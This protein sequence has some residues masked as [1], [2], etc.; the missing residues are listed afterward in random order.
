VV[1]LVQLSH[2]KN[3]T[4][5]KSLEDEFPVNTTEPAD[6]IKC[7]HNLAIANYEGGLLKRFEDKLHPCLLELE[8]ASLS[9]DNLASLFVSY[10]PTA[11]TFSV[12]LLQALETRVNESSV[13]AAC[14]LLIHLDPEQ[15]K[16]LYELLEACVLENVSEIPTGMAQKVVCALG[17]SKSNQSSGL[18]VALASVLEKD[19]SD[20]SL[21]D[22]SYTSLSYAKR[23]IVPKSLMTAIC[24][25][26]LSRS[27]IE[28]PVRPVL[29]FINAFSAMKWLDEKVVDFLCSHLQGQAIELYQWKSLILSCGRLWYLPVTVREQLAKNP[30]DFT[31]FSTKQHVDIAFSLL[32]NEALPTEQARQL[33]SSKTIQSA[34]GLSRYSYSFTKCHLPITLSSFWSV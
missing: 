24:R 7:L 19:L 16:K 15:N 21:Q 30:P 6:C 11:E 23:S 10:K 9:Y 22:L 8:D 17:K 34:L 18:L 20:L 29:H 13:L 27:V 5:L 3:T 14:H 1:R 2:A 25:E 12:D 32:V 33:I 28:L 4:A 31:Q 26:L